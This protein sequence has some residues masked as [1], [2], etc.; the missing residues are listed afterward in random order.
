M[1][2]R[3]VES[4][5]NFFA[6]KQR[7]RKTPKRI[8]AA[9]HKID[10]TLVARSALRV[11]ETLQ[12][13]GYEAFVVGGAVRDLLLG[14]SPRTSTS[15]PTPRRSRSRRCS[16]APSSS[17]GASARARDVRRTRPSRCPPSAALDEPRAPDR[18][19]RAHAARQ[20]VRHRSTKTPRGATSP[21]TRCST[22]RPT[23]QVLDYH[24]GIADIRGKTRAHDRRSGS[25]LPRRPGAHAARGALR[26]QAAASRSS[27]RTREPITR[28]R[29]LLSTTCR[30]R[31][32]STRC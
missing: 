8:D 13:A 23:Q 30:P 25:A 22:T 6:G 4:V 3:F 15:P 14:S 10:K 29:E 1:I 16:A 7:L 21:S 20:R 32:C 17:A 12:E 2:K 27:R 9:E 18:R 31:A 24:G 26:G 28:M 19:T 11:C 5:S